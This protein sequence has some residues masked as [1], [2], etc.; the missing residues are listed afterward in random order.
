MLFRM[1]RLRTLLRLVLLAVTLFF[2]YSLL[3]PIFETLFNFE[4]NSNRSCIVQ[5]PHQVFDETVVKPHLF[6]P[7][8]VK[9]L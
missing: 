7:D 1:K 5:S 6:S 9:G 3:L 2:L 8:L 4:T